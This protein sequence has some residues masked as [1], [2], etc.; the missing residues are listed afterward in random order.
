MNLIGVIKM[1]AKKTMILLDGKVEVARVEFNDEMLG[2]IALKAFNEF[3]ALLI[4][5]KD[6]PSAP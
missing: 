3:V 6:T 2:E 5:P 4:G 1:S